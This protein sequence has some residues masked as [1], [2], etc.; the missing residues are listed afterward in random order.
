MLC[1]AVD[2]VRA[3]LMPQDKLDAIQALRRQ[4]GSVAMVGDGVNDA[5]ALRLADIGIAMGSGTAVARNAADMVLADDNFATIVTAVAEGRGIFNN[6]KQFVRY[7]VSSNIGG[8][9]L[10]C[11]PR[12]FAFLLSSLFFQSF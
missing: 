7:M 2:D 5:P 10:Y 4:Y 9:R 11:S 3:D 1:T 8:F 6:T 12:A